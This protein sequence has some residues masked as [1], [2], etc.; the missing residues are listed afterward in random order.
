MTRFRFAMPGG[1]V[2][3]L[4][5]AGAINL[6]GG[7]A[8][9][10]VRA[11]ETALLPLDAQRAFVADY[12]S[13]CHNDN[14]RFGEM[15]LTS[16][17]LEH[18]EQNAELAEKV[19]RKLKTGLMPP[20]GEVRPSGRDAEAFAASLAAQVDQAAATRPNPGSRPFQR[21]TGDEYANSVR[22]L[23][24]VDVDVTKFLPADSLSEGLDNIADSQ[25]FSA[26]L[27]EG[28]MRAAGQIMR[29]A[30]GDPMA[31]PSS[32]VFQVNRTGSQLMR[33][34]GAPFGTRGGISLMFNFP[35]DGEY[36]FRAMLH[37]T[38]TGQLF[39]NTPDEEIE[40]SIDG[41][42]VA[43][44]PI[45]PQLSESSSISGLNVA[46]GPIFVK[47][48]PRRVSAAFVKKYTV[49]VP[50]D[51]AEI[52]HT[53]IDTDSGD[54]RELTVYAHVREFEISGPRKVSGVSDSAP[55]RRVFT[56][57]P[58]RPQE[59][60]PCATR[61]VRQLARKAYRRPV[62]GE[63]ME[64][65]MLFYD[66][67]RET[68]GNFESGIREALQAMLTS[69]DFV[70]KFEPFP[71]GTETGQ[72]Y[73]IGDLALASRLSYFLWGKPPDDELIDHADQGQLG[74]PSVLEAQVRRML[75]DPGSLW[76]STKFA[77]LW[78]HLPDLENFHPEPYYYP[79]F[80]HTLALALTR[81]TELFFD[82]IVREDRNVLDLITADDTFVNERVAMHYG[83]SNVRGNRFRKVTLSEDYRR[84]LLGK[85]A[86]LALTSN[87]ER[88]SPVLRGKWIMG[89]LLGTP[90]PPPPP[91]VPSLD[92]TEAIT[93]GKVLPVRERMEM[94]RENPACNS[95]HRMIDP[96][97]LALENFDVTGEWRTLDK[98]YTISDGGVR[99][100]A[101]GIPIDPATELYDGTPLD[102]PASLRQA[103]LKYSDAFINT[104]TE[105]LLAFAIGRRV[106][107]FDMPTIRAITREAKTDNNRFSSLILGIVK[108]PAFRMS[109]AEEP[110]SEANEKQ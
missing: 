23:L 64:G 72:D 107:Y 12:C 34:P 68:G 110:V 104:L 98:T 106:E 28:Y 36:N 39:G 35:A 48:G 88:T 94:H 103:I 82:S 83:V 40:V 13:G 26:S 95:C 76:L 52:Q 84:G 65:L 56:C 89:V 85:G 51:M 37:G 55:R 18:P 9:A 22:D 30:L 59:E 101:G 24:G 16:L 57:R 50:D 14:D 8:S 80:D 108:S 43:L 61:I 100:H 11:G 29:E 70:F 63:D 19:I 10:P 53:L 46:T 90:P 47:T 5:V 58:L 6:A 32:T 81:E 86:I 96:L 66:Q 109:R 4:L 33:T 92:D 21:L 54:G 7:Q 75:A 27:M 45:D 15:T 3:C 67:G 44:L 79:Q 74:N 1:A 102:G 42:R 97:G 17:D 38:P 25:T 60:I 62:T 93:S 31:E 69:P 71:E 78:L 87:A 77:N 99:I 41:V 49:I 105:N 73:Y 20:A 2:A 91:S